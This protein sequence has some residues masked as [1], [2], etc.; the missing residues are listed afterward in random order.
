MFDKHTVKDAH[1]QMH[2]Q[3][4]ACSESMHERYC[5]WICLADYRTLGGTPSVVLRDNLVMDASHSA[6][7]LWI[8]GSKLRQLETE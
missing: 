7:H 5:A 6:K 1:V 4:Q 3:V 8:G 2:M